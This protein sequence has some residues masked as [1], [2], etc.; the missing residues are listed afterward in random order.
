[1]KNKQKTLFGLDN[2]I[3][4]AVVVTSSEGYRDVS[5]R[6]TFLADRMDVLDFLTDNAP[7]RVVFRTDSLN[8]LDNLPQNCL[9]ADEI[10]DRRILNNIQKGLVIQSRQNSLPKRLAGQEARE[11][12]GLG[13]RVIAPPYVPMTYSTYRG[14]AK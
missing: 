11:L 7:L 9:V 5:G 2:Y 13:C 6:A 14:E 4:V 1:M 12:K 3:P 8:Y 10:T